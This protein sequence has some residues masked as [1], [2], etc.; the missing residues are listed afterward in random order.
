MLENRI[1]FIRLAKVQTK[2]TTKDKEQKT[3]LKTNYSIMAVTARVFINR[4][5]FLKFSRYPAKLSHISV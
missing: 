5:E 4:Y 1:I 3:W 2:K